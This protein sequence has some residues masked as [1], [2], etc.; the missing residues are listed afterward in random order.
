MKVELSDAQWTRISPHLPKPR[1]TPK[2]VCLTFS[3][4]FPAPQ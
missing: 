3:S 1:P 4:P 2:G